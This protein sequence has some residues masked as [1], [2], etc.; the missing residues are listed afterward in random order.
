MRL[1]RYLKKARLKA[2]LSQRDVAGVLGFR[3]AQFVSNWER[4][5]VAV[6]VEHFRELSKMYQV[7]LG[8]LVRLSVRDFHF[9]LIDELNR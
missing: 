6:P 7:P 4:E 9:G 8:K 1:N 5:L 3:T 2:G